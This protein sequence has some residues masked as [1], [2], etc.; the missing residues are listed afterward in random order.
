MTYRT[1]TFRSSLN[2]TGLQNG[3]RRLR[4]FAL[5]ILPTAKM[6]SKNTTLLFK[7]LSPICRGVARRADGAVLHVPRG[8]CHR[9]GAGPGG[10]HA[11]QAAAAASP[12]R[13]PGPRLRGGQPRYAIVW[14]GQSRIAAR[15]PSRWEF[16]W[17]AMRSGVQG[18]QL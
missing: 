7:F 14:E 15:S 5:G 8:A 10:G 9:H 17:Y 1:Y 3:Q 11:L 18:V 2:D 16:S 13:R 4:K 6:S 12:L